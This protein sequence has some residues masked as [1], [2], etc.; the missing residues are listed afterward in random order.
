MRRVLLLLSVGLVLPPA[1][2]AAAAPVPTGN[3][4]VTLKPGA[5]DR[6]G[7][8]A[9][10]RAVAATAGARVSG[11]AV[12]QIRLVTMR[13]RAGESLAALGRRLRADP[14][15]ASVQP[16]QRG[17]P[18][19]QPNDPALVAPETAKDTAPGTPVQWW[20]ARSGF[21]QAWDITR[22]AGA[23]VAVIDTGAEI[24]HPELAGRVAGQAS[25]D[26]ARSSP[27]VDAIGH[28]T[29]VASIACGAGDNGIG[30]AGAGLN[31][32]LL[33]IK[34]DFTDSSVAAS[35]VWAVDHGADAI[36]M[37]FGTAP[38]AH[39]SKPV[40]DAIDYAVARGVLP[41]SAAADDPVE[42]QGYP[43]SALQP[44]GTG[45]DLA[46]GRG[47]SVTAADF[48]DRRARFAGR[49]TQI[50]LAAYGTYEGEDEDGPPGIFGAFTA[51]PNALDTGTQGRPCRCRATFAGDT[52]YAYLQGTS[53]ATPMV[54]AAAAL[55]HRLNPDIGAL[56]LARILKQTARRPAG[57]GWTPE[58]GWGILDAGTALATVR[59]LDRRPPTSKIR[60]VPRRTRARRLTLRWTGR[61]VPR[62]GVAVTGLGGFELWRSVDG[63]APRRILGTP[64]RSSR[65][66]LR[67][68]SRYAFFT[69]AVDLAGN[70]EPAPRTPD[71]RI[72]VPRG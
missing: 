41:V 67:R 62:A 10:A 70:R 28:G 48:L 11:F 5:G 71:V 69:I 15:V 52:R 27:G 23:T 43:A 56:E 24:A 66:T 60:R 40:I 14:R 42:D 47:L 9:A 46:Q 26:A 25:F 22:G 59:A 63:R 12:P 36:N 49:G 8:R 68:G 64:R 29:H 53:M 39:P 57:S 44:T 30:M 13:P 51:A 54:T 3:L 37:S 17:A 7:R 2:H 50:S 31:C 19:Y 20:A 21:L 55:M 6:S 4:L 45:P 16:E 61:D 34:S 33:I 58:L 32:R 18:R 38:G 72:T 1:A 65:V 35:I